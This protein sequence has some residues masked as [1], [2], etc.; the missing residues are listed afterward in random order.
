MRFDSMM[1]DKM[2]EEYVQSI[3]S[4]DILVGLFSSNQ[5]VG[6]AHLSVGTCEDD[7][8][9]IE[10]GISVE[11]EYQRLGLGTELM[12]AAIT[13]G[14]HV[15]YKNMEILCQANNLPMIKIANKFGAEIQQTHGHARAYIDLTQEDSPAINKHEHGL[16]S[17]RTYIF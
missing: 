4:C 1:T 8:T 10:V 3:K 17:M 15:G 14:Q 2:I 12:H 6:S 9:K 16:A 7:H 13:I 5:M 11:T